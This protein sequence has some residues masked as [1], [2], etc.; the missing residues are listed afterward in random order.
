MR[1]MIPKTISKSRSIARVIVDIRFSQAY[2]ENAV[3]KMTKHTN[4][5]PPATGWSRNVPSANKAAPA[6]RAVRPAFAKNILS[7]SSRNSSNCRDAVQCQQRSQS[8][9][10]ATGSANCGD[11]AA[12]GVE[13]PLPSAPP[14]PLAWIAWFVGFYRRSAAAVEL[15][16][17]NGANPGS[18][19]RPFAAWWRC[20]L[21]EPW[22]LAAS[23][24]FR[25]CQADAAQLRRLVRHLKT[26]SRRNRRVEEHRNADNKA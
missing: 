10:R 16:R 6:K 1:A 20:R 3:E 13:S 14:P 17:S 22:R 21:T 5:I 26:R 11:H 15:S 7:W 25:L 23:D 19:Q 9:Q 2:A 4:V 8:L 18:H 24:G 12:K